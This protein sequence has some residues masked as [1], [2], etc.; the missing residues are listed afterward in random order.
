VTGTSSIRI[1]GIDPGLNICGYGV[2]DCAGATR[3][4][5]REA[6]AIRTDDSLPLGRRITQIHEEI[7]AI[8]REQ[9]P[10]VLAVE[11]LYS[12]YK[13]PRTSVLMAHARGVILLAAEQAGVRIRHM[14]AT[15]VKKGL[16]GN[17]HASKR[18][19]QL[20]IQSLCGLSEPPTPADV[21][22]ALAIAICAARE[23]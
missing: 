22:D 11:Q 1:L 19:M 14:P 5:I 18:Q 13:H 4:A 17:G 12:H 20:A 23:V 10:D 7:T 8:L 2:V 21:A 15:R 3:P 9:A 16:T 6:G